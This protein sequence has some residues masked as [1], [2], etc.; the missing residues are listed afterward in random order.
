MYVL[1]T[2]QVTLV[3]NCRPATRPFRAS[4]S[5]FFFLAVLLIG[6]ALACVPVTIGIAQ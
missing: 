2:L 1:S 5:N 4:S 3:N 6:L